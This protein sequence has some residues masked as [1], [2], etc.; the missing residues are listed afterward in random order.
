[1]KWRSGLAADNSALYLLIKVSIYSVFKRQL[2]KKTMRRYKNEPEKTLLET[3]GERGAGSLKVAAKVAALLET[4]THA[5]IYYVS[6][7]CSRWLGLSF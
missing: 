6:S 2:K 3:E 5:Q 1:M 4:G 7:D